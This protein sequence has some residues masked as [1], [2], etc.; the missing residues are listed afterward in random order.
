MEGVEEGNLGLAPIYSGCRVARF[1]TMKQRT[2]TTR[3]REGGAGYGRSARGPSKRAR[4]QPIRAGAYAYAAVFERAEEG[5]Y[6]VHFPAL[7]ITTQADTMAEARAMARDLLS[8]HIEWLL[9]DGEELP[10]SDVAR[11][12][13]KV[14]V[15]SVD[16][17]R[18]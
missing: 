16:I 1:V 5:G 18:A 10:P 11:G 12:L 15:V 17:K 7:G 4:R 9:R 14:E 13:P 8:G 2:P 3:E 6:V